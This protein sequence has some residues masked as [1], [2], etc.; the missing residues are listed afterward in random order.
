MRKFQN[1]NK[2]IRTG[3]SLAGYTAKQ[4]GKDAESLL[5]QTAEYYA[6]TGEALIYKRYEPYKRVSGGT[7]R[8]FKAVYAGKAGCDYSI[9]LPDGRAG[10]IEVKSR[11]ATRIRIDA[12]NDDQHKQLALMKQFNM[13]AYVLVRLNDQW[14]LIDY[15]KWLHPKRK[16]HNISQLQEIGTLLV[17][18][19]IIKLLD[20]I[21]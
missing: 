4:N 3:R 8:V 18:T 12:L 1:N 2:T 19:H 5:D 9:W 14:Y 11:D 16:S 7:T 10:M 20:A 17:V 13:L 15:D 6:G 21:E